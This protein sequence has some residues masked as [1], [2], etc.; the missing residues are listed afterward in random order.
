MGTCAAADY[1]E[2]PQESRENTMGRLD[3]KVAWV[4]GGSG[5][6]GSATLRRFVQ[7][8]AAVVC[9]DINDVGGHQRISFTPLSKADNA[10]SYPP[11]V[12]K[13][14]HGNF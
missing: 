4:S 8:G 1:P 5:G 3:G 6:I 7:E 12:K 14:H 11:N 10:S 13:G 9:S 2:C